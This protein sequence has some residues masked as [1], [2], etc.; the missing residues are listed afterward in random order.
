MR[1]AFFII[2]S[3]AA[4]VAYFS[5]HSLGESY[6]AMALQNAQLYGEPLKASDDFRNHM[7]SRGQDYLRAYL[8]EQML[9]TVAVN[10]LAIDE[11]TMQAG[12]A[13]ELSEFYESFN[14]PIMAQMRIYA[15]EDLGRYL[16]CGRFLPIQV[17]MDSAYTLGPNFQFKA[18]V[19]APLDDVL[20]FTF[21]S[22]ID[23]SHS[24]FSSVQ[25]Q[26]SNDSTVYDGVVFGLGW[27]F[28]SWRWKMNYEVTADMIQIQH[29]SL[30]TDF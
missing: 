8:R 4:A 28:Y 10:W 5:P 20:R 12:V 14:L 19:E 9:S 27:R 2:I 16:S 26:L 17:E 6:Q 25:Y 1:R 15:D 13:F 23:W 29:M 24:L 18:K 30:A 11:H 22:Q 7:L 21:G 3:S